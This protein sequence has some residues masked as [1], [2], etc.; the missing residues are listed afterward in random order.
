[1]LDIGSAVS[2]QHTPD[3]D[4]AILY[5]QLVF[6]QTGLAMTEHTLEIVTEGLTFKTYV[7]FD[8]AIYTYVFSLP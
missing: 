7:K 1:V 4:V 8:Y 5:N 3:R 2:F 6:R